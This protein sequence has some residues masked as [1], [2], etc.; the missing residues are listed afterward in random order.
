MSEPRDNVLEK[1]KVDKNNYR[2]RQSKYGSCYVEA[3]HDD[4]SEGKWISMFFNC[5]M[6]ED[7]SFRSVSIAKVALS[8]LL[9]SPYP[10]FVRWIYFGGR[11]NKADDILDGIFGADNKDHTVVFI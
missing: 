8:R 11:F 3:H 9:A 4:Q 1:I 7:L 6:G 10:T 5:L 2:I